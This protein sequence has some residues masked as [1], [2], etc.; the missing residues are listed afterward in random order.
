MR[1]LE[2]KSMV[3]LIRVHA[4]EAGQDVAV[5]ILEEESSSVQLSWTYDQ[6]DFQTRSVAGALQAQLDPGSRVLLLFPF[7]IGFVTGFLA[8]LYAGMIA[9]PAYPPRSP[10]HIPRLEAIVDDSSATTI[11][12]DTGTVDPLRQWIAGN[13]RKLEVLCIDNLPLDAVE[14]WVRPPLTPT[15]PAFLQYTSGSTGTPKGVIV[16]HGNLMANHRMIHHSS[17]TPEHFVVV[18][19][20]P[21]YHDMGLIGG[22][23]HPL[24]RGGRSY[25]MSPLAF[26]Q[27]PNLWLQAVSEQRGH[28]L[29]APNFALDIVARRVTP[30]QRATL[31]LSSVKVAYCGSEPIDHGVLERFITCFA[32][33]GFNP[34]AM[35][36]CY[37]LAEATL[38]ATGCTRKPRPMVLPLDAHALAAGTARSAPPGAP[39]RTLVSC[40]QSTCDQDLRIVDPESRKTLPDRLVGE[41]WLRG[42]HVSPGY[43]GNTEL[44][45]EMFQAERLEAPGIPY[46]RTGDLGF[47]LEGEVFVTG[48]LKDVIIIRGRNHYPQDL[49]RV[50]MECHPLVEPYACA[51]FALSG[52]ESER[53]AIVCEVRQKTLTSE[54]SN[55]VASAIRRAVFDEHALAVRTIALLPPRC[56]LKTSSGKVQRRACRAAL[57]AGTLPLLFLWEAASGSSDTSSSPTATVVAVDPSS[58]ASDVAASAERAERVITWLRAYAEQRINSRLMDEHHFIPPNI[59]LDFGNQGLLGIQAPL[60][61]GGLALTHRDQMRIYEQMG[62]IDSTL[63]SFL[64]V[65]NALGLRPLLRHASARQQQEVI[66]RIAQGRHLASFGFTEPAAGSNPLGIEARGI[67]DGKG[68]WRLRGTKKWIGTA[69]WAGFITV[70][71]QLED[72]QGG[73]R[74]ITAFLIPDG[75]SG[76]RHGRE[77][78][79]MGLRAMVQNTVH[80][81]DV[82]VTTDD[83]LGGAGEGMAIA[84]E[85]MKFARLCIGAGALG[86]MKRCVQLMLRYASARTI[87]TGR[88]L[89][90]FMSRERISQLM[91]RIEAL[92]AFVQQFVTWLDADVE[93]PEEFYAAIK[94]AGPESM[95]LA[96]DWL[97]Q[98]LGGRGYI[99]TNL[100]PQIYRDSRLLRI[101]EGPTETMQTFLGT[102]LAYHDGPLQ[103]FL[104]QQPEASPIAARLKDAAA[105]LRRFITQD[106]PESPSFAQQRIAA[107]LGEVGTWGLWFTMVTLQRQARGDG[108]LDQANVWLEEQFADAVS[109]AMCPGREGRWR[110]SDNILLAASAYTN[111]IGD[112]DHSKAAEEQE[113][114]P[115]LRRRSQGSVD[116]LHHSP[117]PSAPREEARRDAPANQRTDATADA[118]PAF[119]ARAV[120]GLMLDWLATRLKVPRHTLDPQS[121]FADLGLDSL[122][123][124]ELAQMLRERVGVAIP[125]TASWNH[126]TVRA[127]SSYV[128]SL[129][130]GTT[131]AP[132]RSA[133]SPAWVASVPAPALEP[134][135]LPIPSEADSTAE[136]ARLLAAELASLKG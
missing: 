36:P 59:V 47:T 99:E 121:A 28:A 76:L 20:L 122:S 4:E 5:A 22:L 90:N 130:A 102:R 31:D 19:W 104:A 37:G 13:G 1:G 8:C 70:F 103:A 88:L 87:S 24:Y 84:H 94:V 35:F 133:E 52:E 105:S 39:Q 54:E 75:R 27:R 16:T 123:A 56:I 10:R 68:G 30:E 9:V 109:R 61:A 33:H 12:T 23:L 17:E 115:L 3:D 112:L 21:Y 128:A 15:T 101:F 80:L 14:T 49:E 95:G 32:P 63:G 83:L 72:E 119:N 26:L 131:Y 89:D 50:V 110:T 25:L 108:S 129:S 120:E 44:T 69:A 81:E 79:T 29:I 86:G 117:R 116:E 107:Q 96:A 51:A 134:A 42:P 18:S 127:L 46:L 124:V 97:M 71:V 34:Q 65:H 100:A 7:G 6:L 77:E 11:L 93:V 113:L 57:E 62:A 45:I 58:Q 78:L 85:A 55:A 111:S 60:E 66:P 91:T 40:G 114:D 125:A 136:L 126:P 132:V 82:P 135:A 98:M 73:Q 67:P 53:V 48:R 118:R 43:W 2:F 74:G 41:I 38:L 106:S 64:G 92:D